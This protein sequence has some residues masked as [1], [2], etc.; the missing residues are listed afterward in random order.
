MAGVV[1]VPWYATVFR[2]DRMQAA[3]EEIAPVAMRYGAT[4]WSVH[5]SKEDGYKFQQMAWFESK[6]DWEKYWY[7]EE[8][9]AWRTRHSGWFQ[10]PIVY[11]WWS[12]TAEGS[13]NGEAEGSVPSASSARAS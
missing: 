11:E 9:V 3:L 7:G 2:A 1:H 6:L 13:L 4:R 10:V 5:R 8:F 12:L